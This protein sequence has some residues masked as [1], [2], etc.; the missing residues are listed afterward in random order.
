MN[1]EIGKKYYYCPWCTKGTLVELREV[2]VNHCIIK[3]VKTGAIVCTRLNS[4]VEITD[5]ETRIFQEKQI[6]N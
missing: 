2:L 1:Y 5:E 3:F 6:D 4:L